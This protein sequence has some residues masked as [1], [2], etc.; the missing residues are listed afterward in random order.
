MAEETLFWNAVTQFANQNLTI[1]VD[2]LCNS[3]TVVNIGATNMTANQVPLA[4]P[5]APAL[6]GES[7][8]FGGHK[9]DIYRGRIDIG[10]TGGIGRAI[11]IQ[12]VYV[13]YAGKKQFET[14]S[15]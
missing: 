4:P 2:R 13:E 3:V 11:I 15:K 14:F 9:K 1:E 10:F 7:F 6:L 8:T 5:V 12:N